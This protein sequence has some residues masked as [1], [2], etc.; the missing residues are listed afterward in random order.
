V[1]AA[2]LLAHRVA[3]GDETALEPLAERAGKLEARTPVARAAALTR[4]GAGDRGVISDVL[5]LALDEAIS[6]KERRTAVM[7]LAD[8]GDRS[9]AKSLIPLINVY[10][11][12]LDVAH[13]LARLKARAAVDAL[14]KRLKRERFVERKAAIM[15]ALAEIG[16]TRVAG[17]FTEELFNETPPPG[18]VA[19]ILKLTRRGRTL[20]SKGK[21]RITVLFRPVPAGSFRVPHATVTRVILRTKTRAAGGHVAIACNGDKVGSVPLFAGEGEGFL[22]LESC[23]RPEGGPIQLSVSPPKDASEVALEALAVLGTRR[24]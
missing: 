15:R 7:L 13:T 22:N 18:A 20:P 17:D 23:G 5:A 4:L 10:Q 9:V 24:R 21:E 12:T 16:D 11:L 1:V 3:H 2:W 8:A 19:A 14:V 6:I